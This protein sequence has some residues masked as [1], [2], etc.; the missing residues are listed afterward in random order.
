MKTL[1][2]KPKANKVAAIFTEISNPILRIIKRL[3][4]QAS[5][6][7]KAN[8]EVDKFTIKSSML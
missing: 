4:M 7:A 2:K 6:L 8:I 1:S 5:I 3:G